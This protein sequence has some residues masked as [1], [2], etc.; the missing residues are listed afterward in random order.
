MTPAVTTLAWMEPSRRAVATMAQLWSAAATRRTYSTSRGAGAAPAA[1]GWGPGPGEL[2][3]FV[4]L[5]RVGWR[6]SPGPAWH[7]PGAVSSSLG[8]AGAVR[9]QAE[10]LASRA[11][12]RYTGGWATVGQ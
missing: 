5:G 11:G 9:R 6:V 2:M 7:G 12:T 1:E 4:L 10:G 3:V 8:R